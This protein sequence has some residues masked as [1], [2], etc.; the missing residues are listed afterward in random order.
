ME[1]KILVPLDYS[2]VSNEVVMIADEWAKRNNAS[3][4]FLRVDKDY[5]ANSD[6]DR[7]FFERRFDYH[8]NP[9]IR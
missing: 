9:A 2:E 6:Q 5:M 4:H 7:D 1:K 3:L 8:L